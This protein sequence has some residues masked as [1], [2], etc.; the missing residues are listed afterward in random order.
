MVRVVPPPV[1]PLAGETDEMDGVRE[2]S[3]VYFVL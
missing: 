3:Y 2:V 1:P